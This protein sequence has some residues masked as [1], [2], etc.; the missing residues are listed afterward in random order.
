[1]VI[2]LLKWDYNLKRLTKSQ[3]GGRIRGVFG[4]EQ[5]T[6]T[7]AIIANPLSSANG[8]KYNDPLS[9]TATTCVGG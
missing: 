6:A 4:L 5:Q 9:R 1:M 7:R 8:I 2:A 3:Y